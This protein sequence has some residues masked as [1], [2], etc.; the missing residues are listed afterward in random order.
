MEIALRPK[1]APPMFR[2]LRLGGVNLW[3][4]LLL[5][6]HSDFQNRSKIWHYQLSAPSFQLL[7]F[8]RQALE[9]NLELVTELLFQSFLVFKFLFQ[10]EANPWLISL[11]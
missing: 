3:L 2:C 8:E 6:L 7:V 11:A 1:L 5:S 4:S 10:D 9:E